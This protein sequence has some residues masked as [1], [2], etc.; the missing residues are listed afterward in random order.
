MPAGSGRSSPTPFVYFDPDTSSWRTCRLSFD[1]GGTTTDDGTG[2]PSKRSLEIWPPSGTW[3]LGAAYERPTSALPT[4]GSG[5]SSLLPTPNARDW[6]DVG[7]FAAHPE[8]AKLAHTI[9][10][11]PTPTAVISRSRTANRTDPNSK[12]HDGVTLHDWVR[13]HGAPSPPPSNDGND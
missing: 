6:K 4:N 5:S 13:L 1:F 2:H 3:D 9:K 12:H 11:L 8:K 10:V 7:D